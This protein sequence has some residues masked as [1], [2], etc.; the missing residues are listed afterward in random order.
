MIKFF[1]VRIY[2]LKKDAIIGDLSKIKA[3]KVVRTLNYE[4]DDLIKG[5]SAIKLNKTKQVKHVKSNRNK[6]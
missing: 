5:F 4:R 6:L 2:N 1:N 3:F